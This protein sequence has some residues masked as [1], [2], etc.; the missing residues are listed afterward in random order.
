[1]GAR[2]RPSLTVKGDKSPVAVPVMEPPRHW[3]CP[4]SSGSSWKMGVLK[5]ESIPVPVLQCQGTVTRG[6]LGLGGSVL[7]TAVTN[8]WGALTASFCPRNGLRRWELVFPHFTDKPV[9]AWEGIS[10]PGSVTVGKQAP[11]TQTPAMSH[12]VLPLSRL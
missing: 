5:Q 8:I 4:Q 12:P 3:G 7:D 9:E 11:P 2:A 10:Q 6:S 1:M